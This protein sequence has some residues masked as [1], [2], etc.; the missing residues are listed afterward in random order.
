MFDRESGL[1]TCTEQDLLGHLGEAY[2]PL[3]LSQLLFP[4]GSTLFKT[5]LAHLLQHRQ[6]A[7][8]YI[9]TNRTHGGIHGG[10]HAEKMA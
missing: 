1:I 4:A 5:N 7:A 9:W 2:A 8:P 3:P 6:D 10:T